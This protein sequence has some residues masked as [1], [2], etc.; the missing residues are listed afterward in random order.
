MVAALLCV[1]PAL[2]LSGG[3]AGASR[4]AAPEPPS[5]GTPA[6]SGPAITPARTS[7]RPGERVRLTIAG[8]ESTWVTIAICGNESRRGSA[9]C[10][11]KSS[12]NNEFPRDGS[13]MRVDFLMSAPP[14]NCPCAIRVVGREVSELAIVPFQVTGHPVGELIDP[15]LIGELVTVEVRARPAS[16]TAL[17]VLRASL[18]GPRRYEVTAVVTNVSSVALTQ[19]R[20]V[21]RAERRGDDDLAPVDFA[22]PGF[23]AVGQ[24]WQQTVVVEVPA[25]TYSAVTWVAEAGGAGPIVIATETRR[26][27]PWLLILLV[28]VAAASLALIVMR[29]ALRRRGELDERLADDDVDQDPVRPAPGGGLATSP[30][31]R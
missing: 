9:D 1:V 29:W 30:T 11:M 2:L 31:G 27:R 3:D 28:M 19:V 24:T 15:P 6:V 10:D 4:S 20:L 13:Q 25:P 5:V 21:A 22:D 8:F 18:G 12:L 7:A 23:V 17:D 26:D 14:V 16:G